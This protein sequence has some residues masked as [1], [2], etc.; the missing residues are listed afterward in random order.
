M[1]SFSVSLKKKKKVKTWGIM[2]KA[3]T[4]KVQTKALTLASTGWILFLLGRAPS[5]IKLDLLSET[6]ETSTQL[7]LNSY[8]KKNRNKFFYFC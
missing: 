4:F 2:T 7:A 6:F 8:N 5:V 3:A 1:V